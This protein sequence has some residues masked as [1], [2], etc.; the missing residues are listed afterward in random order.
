MY[1]TRQCVLCA[2]QGIHVLLHPG[3]WPSNQAASGSSE[4]PWRKAY[5]TRPCS[6]SSQHAA[7]RLS[8]PGAALIPPYLFKQIRGQMC[9][10]H[11]MNPSDASA[12]QPLAAK[13]LMLTMLFRGPYCLRPGLI[14]SDSCSYLDLESLCGVLCK[15]F[16][17]ARCSRLHCW[18][19][20]S[21]D[22]P[23]AQAQLSK[24]QAGTG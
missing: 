4:A 2:Y 16:G 23:R 12:S 20:S 15:V 19:K 13:A 3:K 14:S 22:L 18:H 7:A 1:N 24:S 6:V 9:N 21:A 8:D 5:I 11:Y 17:N 10:S